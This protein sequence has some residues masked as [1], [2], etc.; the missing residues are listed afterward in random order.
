M[1]VLRKIM[2]L[3]LALT[4]VLSVGA[5]TAVAAEPAV[6]TA[7][8]SVI[9]SE[10]NRFYPQWE[11]A[12]KGV[13]YDLNVRY[14]NNEDDFDPEK[15]KV[16]W[17]IT[18]PSTAGI[19]ALG[20]AGGSY[21]DG[22]KNTMTINGYGYFTLTIKV[23]ASANSVN[24][25]RVKIFT[26]PDPNAP[27]YF[28]YFDEYGIEN[29]DSRMYPGQTMGYGRSI[30]RNISTRTIEE[31]VSAKLPV[32]VSCDNASYEFSFDDMLQKNDKF[33]GA[34]LFRVKK[35]ATG[36]VEWAVEDIGREF[37]TGITIT[38]AD[39][40]TVKYDY[41]TEMTQTPSPDMLDYTNEVE[42]GKSYTQKFEVIDKKDV[43]TDNMDIIAD[44]KVKTGGNNV[45][46][47]ASRVAVQAVGT[48]TPL[49]NTV[50][51]NGRGAVVMN[52]DFSNYPVFPQ[53]KRYNNI[54][55]GYS[56]TYI[57]KGDAV[58][59][60]PGDIVAAPGSDSTKTVIDVPSS[61]TLNAAALAKIKELAAGKETV[62][63]KLG[64]VSMA[65]GVSGL[66]DAAFLEAVQRNGGVFDPL[67]TL[68]APAQAAAANINTGGRWFDFAHTGKLP[69]TSTISLSV[70]D[71]FK[72][73][74]NLVLWYF[75]EVTG[76]MEKQEE[77]AVDYDKDSG[78][79]SFRL[80]HCSAWALYPDIEGFSPNGDGTTP[81]GNGDSS[82]SGGSG[83]SA[84]S[85]PTA[86][87]GLEALARIKDLTPAN[88]PAN[89][90]LIKTT[91]GKDI[92]VIPVTLIN[93]EM[94]VTNLSLLGKLGTNVGLE[95]KQT[96]L[97]I[98]LPGGFG[99]VTEVGRF[100]FPM[101]FNKVAANKAAMLAA[102]KGEGALSF[103][104]T[105]GGNA[106]LP[107]IATMTL[108][109]DIK[110]D[111]N[112]NVYRFDTATGKLVF[113]AKSKVAGGKVIFDTKQLG[114][115]MVTTGTL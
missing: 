97:D 73:A 100:S 28:A 83:S 91:A 12:A 84:P 92:A 8:L 102:V 78:N 42:V 80:D 49:E 98:L 16:T 93:G 15:V 75:N 71:F 24:T 36:K 19:A 4:L 87:K 79:C 30:N 54:H 105:I 5:M 67:I 51:F 33:Y 27:F 2:A 3:T 39:G 101:A 65:I 74:E 7:E 37:K 61:N 109:T 104:C 57:V 40:S 63:L 76:K 20:T 50:K 82:S 53:E 94:G 72:D 55:G 70:G 60:A 77:I 21:N 107:T 46:L 64:D 96:G 86:D 25:I 52:I 110:K 66:D 113:V 9:D 47:G 111:G 69:G 81:G 68:A 44:W 22:Y 59:M 90:K 1:R 95:I 85:Y 23:A 29:E 48:K 34:I 114:Q 89:A 88:L 112:V 6:P 99:A 31:F 62:E 11:E 43:L 103:T 45:M 14:N 26:E 13:T 58:P 32:S 115:F 108:T 106:T 10:G 38:F 18:D 41:Y 35:E 17:E 56:L